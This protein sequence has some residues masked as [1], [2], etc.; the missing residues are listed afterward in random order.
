MVGSL[1][2]GGGDVRD[3]AFCFCFGWVG[4]GVVGFGGVG[5]GGLIGLVVVR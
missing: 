4:V 3:G 2:F 1:G 5:F